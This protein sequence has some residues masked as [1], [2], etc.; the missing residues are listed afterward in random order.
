MPLGL[1]YLLT[2]YDIP[3]VGAASWRLTVGSR[4][5]RPMLS[6]N[7][8]PLNI[9]IPSTSERGGDQP[10]DARCGHDQRARALAR[11]SRLLLGERSHPVRR[12]FA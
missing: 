3:V 8:V 7:D 12:C 4:V 10:R 2:Q 6:L 9:R 5:E 11:A 1:H